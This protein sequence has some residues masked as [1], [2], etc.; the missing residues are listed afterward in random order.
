[1]S[2]LRMRSRALASKLMINLLD[3]VRIRQ[4]TAARDP[5]R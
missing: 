5:P 3:L 2:T 4:K 1:M